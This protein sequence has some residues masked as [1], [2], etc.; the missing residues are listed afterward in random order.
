MICIHCNL[1]PI[2]FLTYLWFAYKI[3]LETTIYRRN[4]TPFINN[5]ELLESQNLMLLVFSSIK[6]CVILKILSLS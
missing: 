1:G 5:N 2:K 3:K 6:A 4:T